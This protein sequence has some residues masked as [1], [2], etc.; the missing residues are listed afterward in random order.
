MKQPPLSYLL[1]LLITLGFVWGSGYSLAKYATNGGVHPL[2]YGFWQA[3]GP[4]LL[5][6]VVNL[7]RGHFNCYRL[8]YWPY[9]LICGLLGI[10]IPNTNMYVLA[11]L[12][13]A[14][15]L[16]VLVNTVPLIVYPLTL[17]LKKE[18]FD[19]WRFQAIILGLL[20]L[21]LL[22]APAA[23]TVLSRWSIIALISPVS[24]ALCSIYI[25]FFQP[26]NLT[27]LAC[28]SGML[29]AASFMLLPI[30]WQ[31]QLFYPLT[32]PYTLTKLVVIAEIFL[33]SLGYFIFF[34]LLALAGPVFY[35]FTGSVVALTGLFWGIVIFDESLTLRQIIAVGCLLLAIVL[36]TWR[37]PSATAN[38]N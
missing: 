18:K 9:Y 3:A 12:L 35:G 14:G 13:P 16:A 28:A 21:V 19:G 38:P 6:T 15:L 10:V 20:G 24:F 1:L 36:M 8:V 4:A 11:S 34:K 29:I 17:I 27:P 22:I 2:S 7:S 30:I 37:Q 23:N 31:Q 5:L 26:K 25:S 33:S 32:S